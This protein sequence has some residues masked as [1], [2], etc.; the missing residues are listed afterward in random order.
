M[1]EPVVEVHLISND[2]ARS[3]H[4]DARAGLTSSPKWLAP[5]WFYDARGSDLFEEITQH[6]SMWPSGTRRTSGS[7]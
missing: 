7:R 4:R 3:L 1:T 6:T 2:A 5:K